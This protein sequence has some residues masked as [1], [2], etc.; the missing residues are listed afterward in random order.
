MMPIRKRIA[1]VAHDNF[2]LKMVDW[3]TRWKEVL[4]NHSLIGTGTTSKMIIEETGRV[5]SKP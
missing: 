4:E 1:L 2:K 5:T 3:C